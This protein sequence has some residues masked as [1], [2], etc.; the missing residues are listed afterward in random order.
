MNLMFFSSNAFEDAERETHEPASQFVPSAV[1]IPVAT[2]LSEELYIKK[3][4]EHLA[5]AAE[6]LR[7]LLA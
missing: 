1:G 6:H 5:G 3:N 7:H 4:E 2:G